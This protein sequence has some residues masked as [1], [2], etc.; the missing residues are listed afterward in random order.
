MDASTWFGA[1]PESTTAGSGEPLPRDELRTMRAE[2]SRSM[3]AVLEMARRL[4]ESSLDLADSAIRR[5][6]LA[7]WMT[8]ARTTDTLTIHAAPGGTV[9]ATVWVHHREHATIAK[10]RLSVTPLRGP[11]GEDPLLSVAFEP[12]SLVD[13]VPGESRAVQLHVDVSTDCGA[14]T[15]WG[16]VLAEGM[17]DLALPLRLD[18]R[19]PD[20]DA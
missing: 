7:A 11:D 6:N 19:D 20:G 5:P 9:T 10:V 15:Y 14:G 17:P 2:A 18:V 12:E 16:L 13:V 4:F 1:R 3:D 8:D